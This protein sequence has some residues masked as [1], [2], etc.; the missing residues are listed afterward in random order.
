MRVDM[1]SVFATDVIPCSARSTDIGAA[2]LRRFAM[3]TITTLQNTSREAGTYGGLVDAIGGVATVV[4][5]IIALSGI[6]APQ[7]DAIAIIVFGAALLIQAGTMLTEYT[8]LIFPTGMAQSG[9]EGVGGGL[10]ALFLVGAAGIVLGILSLLN[11]VPSML[12]AAA[13][14]A[15]GAALLLSSNSVWHLH[16]AKQTS[17]RLGGGQM[18]SGSE[19]LAGEMASGSAGVQCVAG[20]TGIVLGILAICGIYTDILTLV[21]L[22]VLGATVLLT[23]STLSG[24]AMGS[25][26]STVGSSGGNWSQSR[27]VAE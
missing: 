9:E 25:G 27:G 24:T 17:L 8:K 18:L 4:L 11:V 26:D 21:A 19:I 12:M 22:L 6:D 10:P 7:L 3:S 2:H 14:I 20:L 23:G 15:F 13:V 5:A 1:R 16:R